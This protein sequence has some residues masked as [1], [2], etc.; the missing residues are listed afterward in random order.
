[1]A[2]GTCVCNTGVTGAQCTACNTNYYNYPQCSCKSSR[3]LSSSRSTH[4]LRCAC[5]VCLC[6]RTFDMDCR[7]LCV[8]IVWNINSLPGELVV[9]GARRVCDIGC[10]CERHRWLQLQCGLQ[11]HRLLA[12]RRQLL[13]LPHLHLYGLLLTLDRS[14][15][16]PPLPSSSLGTH[17][18]M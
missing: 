5:C 15:F 17:T 1:M 14:V 10:G 18:A 4:R 13:R 7:G 2:T 9:P 11:W 16:Y 3:V 8:C 6:A 12:L